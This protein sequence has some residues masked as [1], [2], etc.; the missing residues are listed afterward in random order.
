MGLFKDIVGGAIK[1]VKTIV[2]NARIGQQAKAAGFIQPSQQVQQQA[3][4]QAS[5]AKSNN[6]ILI[7]VGLLTFIGILI[8][9]FK[10]K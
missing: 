7:G 8:A 10:K 6:L 1:G 9:I 3:T 2:Q 5:V 4:I